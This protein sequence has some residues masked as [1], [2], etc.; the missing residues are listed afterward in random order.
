RAQ[1]SATA[2]RAGETQQGAELDELYN[3]LR[4]IRSRVESI[5]KTQEVLVRAERDRIL[6]DILP[7]FEGDVVLARVYL[8]VD[9]ARSQRQIVTA[10]AAASGHGASE[11]TVSR[12]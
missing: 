8:L 3:E 11:A 2:P 4:T 7:V 6:A 1:A 5:E 12:K 9:G 10:I